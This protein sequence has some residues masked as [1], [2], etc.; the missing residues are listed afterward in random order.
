MQFSQ[1][2]HDDNG[3]VYNV[4]ADAGDGDGNCYH[5]YHDDVDHDENDS[6]DGNDDCGK[7]VDDYDDV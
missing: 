3:V 1:I 5:H 6:T 2:N 7:N 4:D